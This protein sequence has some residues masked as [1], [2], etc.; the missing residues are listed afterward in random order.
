MITLIL[1][2]KAARLHIFFKLRYGLDTLASHW[3]V[4]LYK[5]WPRLGE[6]AEQVLERQDMIIA[7]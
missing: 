2:G 1:T 7:V 3:G 5:L 4:L 6:K